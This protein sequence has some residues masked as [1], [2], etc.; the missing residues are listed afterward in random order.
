MTADRL[1]RIRWAVRAT[2]VLGIA[3]SVTANVLHAEDNPVSRTIAAWPPLALLLTVELISRVPVTSRALSVSRLAA[4]TVIAGIAA[5]VSYVHM[6][7]VA[8]RYGERGAS[9]YLLPLS[10][11]GLIVVASICLVELGGRIATI[12]AQDR[13]LDDV[14]RVLD[15][16]RPDPPP[17]P[18]TDGPAPPL[19]SVPLGPERD[20]ILSVRLLNGRVVDIDRATEQVVGE[21]RTDPPSESPPPERPGRRRRR[22]AAPAPPAPAD[23]PEAQREAARAL[24]RQ[25]VVDGEPLSQ[26]ELGARFRRSQPWAKGRIDEVHAEAV[27]VPEPADR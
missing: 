27:R 20:P 14:A 19:A 15:A 7:G 1:H 11:D 2:L 23:G 16:R 5:Y 12:A 25:S 8:F 18:P 21:G 3:A 24:Y 22:T 9:P 26:R 17:A 6:T 13:H 4:T 10:V